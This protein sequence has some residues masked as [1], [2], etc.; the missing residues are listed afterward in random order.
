MVRFASPVQQF[1][2]N[3]LAGRSGV[4]DD[5]L[6]SARASGIWLGRTSDTSARIAGTA[7]GV[8]KGRA[9]KPRPGEVRWGKLEFEVVFDPPWSQNAAG[10]ASRV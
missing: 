8:A 3:G 7:A 6:S 2:E 9:V 10:G 4:P 5:C 1:G